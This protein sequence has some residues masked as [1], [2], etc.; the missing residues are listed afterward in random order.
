MNAPSWKANANM[1]LAGK[2]KE[3]TTNFVAKASASLIA[4][5]V[6]I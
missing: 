6:L 3:A 1:V 5:N 2:K 4:K